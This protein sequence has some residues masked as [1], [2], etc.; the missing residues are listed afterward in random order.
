MEKN[1]YK[2]TNLMNKTSRGSYG[3]KPTGGFWYSTPNDYSWTE[4]TVD[5][6][7]ADP[8]KSYLYEI[9][10]PYLETIKLKT[11]KDIA[12]FA[13]RFGYVKE[14]ITLREKKLVPKK[15]KYKFTSS[16]LN[17]PRMITETI[18]VEHHELLIDWNKVSEVYGNILLMGS[19]MPHHVNFKYRGVTK[20]GEVKDIKAF[21]PF[22]TTWDVDGGVII[23]PFTPKLIQVLHT[24]NLKMAKGFKELILCAYS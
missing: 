11:V 23:Q 12:E 17:E 22:Q 10:N 14:K 19:K 4:W 24:L 7:F 15:S 13:K 21:T 5:E 20:E 9:A 18:N 2:P 6:D 3:Y 8:S 1:P 16:V